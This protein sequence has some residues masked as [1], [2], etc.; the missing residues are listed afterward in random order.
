MIKSF[1]HIKWIFINQNPKKM[2][3]WI[4]ETFYPRTSCV[5]KFYI[6]LRGVW[7]DFR[8]LTFNMGRLCVSQKPMF[9]LYLTAVVSDWQF[10]L[11]SGE[12]WFAFKSKCHRIW[13]K[14]AHSCVAFGHVFDHAPQHS[15]TV[16]MFKTR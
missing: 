7:Q 14:F 5:D 16:S 8:N 15:M 1:I 6:T 11:M 10:V 13:I 9:W 12:M 4:R 2:T 3:F